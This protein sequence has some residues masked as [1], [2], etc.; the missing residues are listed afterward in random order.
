MLT[1]RLALVLVVCRQ[2]PDY[3]SSS[4]GFDTK[5]TQFKDPCHRFFGKIRGLRPF[6][7]L[8]QCCGFSGVY[9]AS[10]GKK[11]WVRR[12]SKCLL[13]MIYDGQRICRGF[14][15]QVAGLFYR[16]LTETDSQAGRA[17]CTVIRACGCEPGCW[18]VAWAD[19]DDFERV[20]VALR[21]G[22][23][24]NVTRSA[25]LTR[26]LFCCDALN[27]YCFGQVFGI[28]LFSPILLRTR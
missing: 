3:S 19:D 18:C 13:S 25:Y 22:R 1:N 4:K 21:K 6:E 9:L 7:G 20:L 11:E 28:L 5:Y 2:C 8:T 26:I 24:A 16:T 15:D 23:G 10:L 17:R 14:K 27:S 12:S